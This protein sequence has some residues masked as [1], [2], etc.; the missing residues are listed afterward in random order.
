MVPLERELGVKLADY[1]NL[2]QG[3]LTVAW[4]QNG[5]EGKTNQSPGF[6]LLLDTKDKSD[7]LK[8]N[9]ADVK[10]KWVDSGKQL[11]S[12]K[13]RDIE[14]TTLIVNGED[15]AKARKNVFPQSKDDKDESAEDAQKST[16]KTELIIGQTKPLLLVGYWPKDLE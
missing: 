9:L 8:K 14:F 4:T 10:Q 7:Q 12:E 16:N 6:L 13:I 1:A 3:Q 15:M 2:A 11:K 5:W